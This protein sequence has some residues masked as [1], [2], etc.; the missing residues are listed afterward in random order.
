MRV[1]QMIMAAEQTRAMVNFYEACFDCRLTE[2]GPIFTGTFA[3]MPFAICPNEIAAVDA[4]Q[5]R[6]QMELAVSAAELERI[7]SA[8]GEAGGQFVES[9]DDGSPATLVDPDGNT[10]LVR[11]EGPS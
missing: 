1:V 5:S 10:I 11:S 7:R 8:V 6:L 4:K 2:E 3:G 9:P